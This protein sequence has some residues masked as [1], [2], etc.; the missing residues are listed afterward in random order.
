M[1][2]KLILIVFLL[3]NEIGFGQ[4][5]KNVCLE[6]SYYDT[7]KCSMSPVYYCLKVPKG[8]K[9][10]KYG[11]DC[12]GFII[13][14][15]DSGQIYIID[16]PTSSVTPNF[17]NWPD[18]GMRGLYDTLEN[19]GQ[20]ADGK[21]WREWLVG[22]TAIVGYLGISENNKESFDWALKSL[23][24]SFSPEKGR[25]TTTVKLRSGEFDP[26]TKKFAGVNY[27]ID[28][29]KGFKRGS[30]GDD[31]NGLMMIYKDSSQLYIIDDQTTD[32]TPNYKNWPH[33]PRKSSYDTLE[34]QGQDA[35]GKVWREQIVGEVILGYA[36][37]PAEKKEVFDKALRS[38]RR[39][40]K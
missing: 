1:K 39:E 16:D 26:V 24:R 34:N 8:Y 40:K 37:V 4:Y 15:R 13:T 9:F 10:R 38:L 18:K 11:S 21:Y 25:R 22:N 3:S 2:F 35:S 6:S 36:G 29:P 27:F 28:A 30:V 17:K 12:R 14:Y 23:Q 19:V 7:T 5:L 32:A 31:Y 20:S 33:K